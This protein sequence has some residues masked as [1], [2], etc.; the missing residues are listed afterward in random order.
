MQEKK[1]K[2]ISMYACLCVFIFS[3]IG[4]IYIIADASVS[5]ADYI[6]ENMAQDFRR[7][8][9]GIGNAFD[10][11]LFEALILSI[12]IIIF[13]V[14]YRAVV[15]FQ[16]GRGLR[17]II[18]LAASVLLIYSGHLLALGVGYKTSDISEKMELPDTKVNEENLTRIIT[19]L[20]DEVNSLADNVPRN[21]QGV[22]DPGYSFEEIS[23]K[24]SDS[25]ASLSHKYGFAE[26]FRSNAKGFET[27]EILSYLGIT[28]IYTYYTGEANVNTS[29]PAYVRIFTTAHEMC[30]QRGILREND[31]NFVAYLIT[32]TSDDQALR[33]SGALNMYSYF[34]S[35]LYKTNKEAFNSVA[36]TLSESSKTDIRAS[37]AVYD[38]YGDTVLERISDW[39]NNLYLKSNGTEGIIS[40]SKV[41][42]LVVAY[43]Q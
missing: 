29:Y 15:A 30:H 3:V 28:G 20:V 43:Y 37:N 21:E 16:R 17:F 35:A 23:A 13:L 25:Y 22:F 32:S 33:Y 31:A 42:E 27:G 2:I 40:Y 36:E 11:S 34:A 7:F 18:N 9:A 26:D 10:F 6:N 38:K 19:L 8:M 24:V 14:S 12:P 1:R 5:F 39:V 41:V 4:V